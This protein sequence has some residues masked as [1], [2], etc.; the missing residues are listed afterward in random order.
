MILSSV[1]SVADPR[2][3]WDGE[4]PASADKWARATT[5]PIFVV[6][7]ENGHRFSLK[8]ELFLNVY[9]LPQNDRWR[10]ECEAVGAS[11]V[12]RGNTG[13]E[14]TLD[15]IKRFRSVVQSYLEMRPFEMTIE[16]KEIWT[17][18]GSV[19]D[20]GK[21]LST[22]PIVLKQAGKLVRMRTIDAIVEWEDGTRE[23]VKLMAFDELFARFRPGQSFEVLV[24]RDPVSFRVTRAEAIR[25]LPTYIPATTS[26]RDELWES[27][28][29]KKGVLDTASKAGLD[30]IDEKYWLKPI[31]KS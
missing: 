28:V 17:R 22:K 26:E 30:G 10:A 9:P 13:D 8:K 11:V 18:I 27:V 25:K 6:K 23:K 14:A 2:L 19:I 31:E 1:D 5:R 24:S 15:W 29:G 7:D 16:D 3:R 20:I 12:G 21:Y 4:S